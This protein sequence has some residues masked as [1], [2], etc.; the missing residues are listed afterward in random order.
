MV[1]K[2]EIKQIVCVKG[3]K[4]VSIQLNSRLKRKIEYRNKNFETDYFEI[5]NLTCPLNLIS[6]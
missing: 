4:R 1:R 5:L 3:M 2:D 6:L